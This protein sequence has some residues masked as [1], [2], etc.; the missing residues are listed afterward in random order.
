TVKLVDNSYVVPP[1]STTTVDQYTGKE[2]TTTT[3]SYHVNQKS[4][5]ITIKNQ[6]FTPYTIETNV[7]ALCGPNGQGQ[8][9]NLYYE[10]QVKGHFGEDWRTFDNLYHVIQSESGYTVVSGVVDY[11]ANSQLDF[12]V[13]ASI[14]YTYDALRD[15]LAAMYYPGPMWSVQLTT[16]QSDWSK[17]QTYTIPPSSPSQTATLPPINS[18]GNSQP[19]YPNQIQSPNSIFTNP[20]FTLGVSIILVGVV[21]AAVMVFLRR[22]LKTSTYTSND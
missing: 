12:R 8:E 5:E 22:H 1:Y 18:E 19:Q 7:P 17:I 14:G 16:N 9:F 21:V 13:R 4:I 6:P 10:V 20:L 15:S 11:G 2:T 3:P